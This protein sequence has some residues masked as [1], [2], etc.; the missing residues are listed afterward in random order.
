MSGSTTLR[1]WLRAELKS[2]LERKAG[3]APLV[4][5]CDP[6]SE[7][8]DLL[9][10]AGE[11]G[12]FELWSG[13]EHE[14][15]LRERLLATPPAPRVIWLPV[16][17]NDIGYLKVFELQADLVWT[18][19]LVSALARFGVEIARDHEA[20]LRHL[21]PAHAKEWIDRP[22]SAWRE[23]TPGNAKTTLV[24]DDLVLLTLASTGRTVDEVVGRDRA[25]VLSRRVTE[26]F[27]L[28]A[29]SGG[30]ADEWRVAA[31]ARLIVTEARV[32]VP[33]EPPGD[34]DKVIPSGPVRERAL[35][36]LDRWLKNIELM[37]SFEDL[38]R[39][40]DATTSLLY[41]ARNLSS[42]VA[43]LAS[44]AAEEALFQKQVAQLAQLDQFDEL[45]K[46]L[47]TWEPFYAAHSM[48]FW[49]CHAEHRIPWQSL[50]TLART[51]VVLRQHAGAEAQWTSP[52]DA[53][54]WFTSTGWEIDRQGD[55]LHSEDPGLP[56]G[57]NGVR[58]R[59]RRAYL[60]RLDETNSTFSELLHH[61]GIESLGLP[62][63]GEL[64]A[65]ARPSR[66]PMA[67]L[68][69]DACRYDLGARIA[70]TL[71]KGEPAR[72]S[73]IQ[74][75]RAPLPSMTCL[76]MPFA[77]VDDPDSLVV[78]LANE[79]PA[80]WRVTSRESTDDLA[81]AEARRDWLRKRFKLKPAAVTDVKSVLDSPPPGPKE[82]GRLLFVFGDEFDTQGH[83]GELKFSGADEQIERYVRAV[84]RI[85]DA[86]YP[87]VAIVTDHGYIHW[88][89]EK[90]E[91]EDLPAGEVLWRSRR[92][93]VGRGLKH[94]T[95]IAVGVKG[96]DLD[97]MVP[98][99]V[100]AFRTYGKMG[101]FH[102]GATL[103]EL[104]IPVV[105]FRWPK[106]AEKISVVLTP[107]S[108]ITS[109]KPRIELKPGATGQP[110]LFGADDRMM[111]RE[112]FVKVVEPASGRRLFRAPQRYKVDPEG[113]SIVVALDREK[114][115]TC[116]RGV[117]LQIEVRDAD[118]DELLDHCQVE[119]RIDLEEW[120]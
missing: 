75:A 59:L 39:P 80:R 86:G 100:N 26:D 95:A 1:E 120:D 37:G 18:E 14:L 64:L 23:L 110:G 112:V 111:G 50:L 54:G 6:E 55:I 60:R 89:P 2:V 9:R 32:R 92:A 43:P 102:G 66:D 15:V 94:R 34:A 52:Q 77:I 74:R 27:G 85:R 13:G 41:W 90:D 105:I 24:D 8:R 118:N 42:A 93:V 22:L 40:A 31:V 3:P 12:A 79:A 53:V 56:S 48:G 5:W 83:E 101:Y 38:A 108:E 68:V 81:V 47:E 20:E 17:S 57:L 104:V 10:A 4:L 73:E 46:R 63:A 69:L 25:G 103:Q 58:A 16:G 28:P 61:H 114:S 76:G 98:R 51:A 115:E 87:T 82:S 21:L 91:V 36:L 88:E 19:S 97:C 30:T 107:L 99:S 71:N 62:F 29:H 84:R 117:R 119:L 45:A 70:E 33:S 7:W 96:S 67:V 35:K 78:D 106:K 65:K 109:V 11:G 49:G 113:Q 72:R 44:R 116:Q